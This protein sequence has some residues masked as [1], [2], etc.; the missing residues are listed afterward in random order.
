MAAVCKRDR[1]RVMNMNWMPYSQVLAWGARAGPRVIGGK[2]VSIGINKKVKM[3]LETP[4]SQVAGGGCWGV[5]VSTIIGH[6]MGEWFLIH[7]S[8]GHLLWVLN[9]NK[10]IIFTWSSC[11]VSLNWSNKDYVDLMSGSFIKVIS[12]SWGHIVQPSLHHSAI[13]LSLSLVRS[14]AQDVWPYPVQWLLLSW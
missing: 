8:W 2:S 13:S 9:H 6:V 11:L 10:L 1:D 7:W 12:P 4:K 3:G 14:S 5:H